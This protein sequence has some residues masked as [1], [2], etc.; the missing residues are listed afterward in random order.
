MVCFHQIYPAQADHLRT[1]L[2]RGYMT[3]LSPLEFDRGTLFSDRSIGIN[4]YQN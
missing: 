2:L 3:D 1:I 4:F